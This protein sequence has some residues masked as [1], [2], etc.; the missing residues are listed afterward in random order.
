MWF[1]ISKITYFWDFRET[2]KQWL[3]DS[4]TRPVENSNLHGHV[5]MSCR[6]FK[7]IWT[8]WLELSK[9]KTHHRQ[10]DASCRKFEHSINKLTQ[11][12][13]NSNPKWAN[14]PELSKIRTYMDMLTWAVENSNHRGQT[15]AKRTKSGPC[16]QH[17][18]W[19]WV[20]PFSTCITKKPNL[21]LKLV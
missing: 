15:L 9:I 19:V 14:R 6:K 5:D 1:K 13:E 11:A 17:S 4:L 21:K 18:M 16:F 10:I 20:L 2:L 3:C 8:C 7:P 12:V